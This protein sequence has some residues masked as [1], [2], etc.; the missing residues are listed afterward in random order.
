MIYFLFYFISIKSV[1][2]IEYFNAAKIIKIDSKSIFRTHA[3]QF[4]PLTPKQLITPF[5][6]PTLNDLL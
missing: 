5:T 1:T 6:I 4:L 3:T 2:A